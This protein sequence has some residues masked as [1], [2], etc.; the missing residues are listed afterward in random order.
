MPDHYYS[1]NPDVESKR[2]ELTETISGKQFRFYADSG[3][4][5]KKG[6]DYGTRLL[7]ETFEEP[8]VSKGIYA[9]A[10]CGWGPVGIYL[11]KTSPGRKV[12]MTDINERAV[13]LAKLNGQLNGVEDRIEVMQNDLLEG[14]EEREIAAVLTNPPIRAGKQVIFRLYEQAAEALVEGGELWV[15]IQK[16][17]GAPSTIK[18]LEELGLETEVMKKSR[19]YFILRGKKC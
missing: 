8:S 9:D 6:L 18:K 7:L 12:L 4:F 13:E 19:G 16:K 15:V 3:V 1:K 2:V 10:G 11:A 14:M 17:Q 5:S